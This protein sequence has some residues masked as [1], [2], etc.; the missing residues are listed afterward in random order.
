M[1]DP[2]LSVVIMSIGRLVSVVTRLEAVAADFSCDFQLRI[3][4][5]LITLTT[6]RCTHSDIL[7]GSS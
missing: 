2:F 4:R 7:L 5:F 1:A 6:I 3:R